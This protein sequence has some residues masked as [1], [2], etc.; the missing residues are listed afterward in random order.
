MSTAALHASEC[1]PRF[2]HRNSSELCAAATGWAGASRLPVATRVEGAA[3]PSRANALS[4]E[5]AHAQINR[6]VNRP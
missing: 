1:G 3:E 6:H 2:P 4:I 5:V